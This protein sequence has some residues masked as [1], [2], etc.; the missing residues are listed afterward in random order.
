MQFFFS[1]LMSWPHLPDDFAEKHDSAWIWASNELYDPNK[2]QALYRDAIN[3]LAYAEE[4]GFDGV[5]VH[6]H[7]QTAY[8]VTP[9]PNLLAAALTQRTTRCKIAVLG[10]ALPLYEPPLRVAEELGMLD[11]LSGGRIVAG[12]LLGSGPEYFIYA[13]NPTTA[14]EK[15]REAVELIVGC[16]TEPGPFPWNSKHYH[17]R[18]V[19]PWPTP[20]QKPHPPIWIVDLGIPEIVDLVAKGLYTYFG[21]P[22]FHINVYK[23]LFQRFRDA[24]TEHGYEP[25]PEQIGWSVPIYVAETD[26]QARAEFENSMW[27]FVNN[28]FK[29]IRTSPPG[30][31]SPESAVVLAK[32]EQSFLPS[33]KTWSQIEDGGFVICGSPE[34]VR[35]KLEN[36]SKELGIG[37][38]V[39]GC[40][41]GK[42]SYELTRKSMELFAREVMPH[43][44]EGHSE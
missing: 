8:A 13:V 37:V 7:H 32:S 3:T 1:H 9:S 36:Y 15:F 41:F 27:Y 40:Q 20:L 16:W 5:C 26:Q 28:M 39:T 30:Y 2:G 35:Q 34:T 29:G 18:Y 43:S 14:R 23:E 31:L 42:L 33:Q 10:N 44:Q 38:V 6:E 24:C 4:L 11:V 22:Y 12:M 21:V 25:H 17:F 19:N